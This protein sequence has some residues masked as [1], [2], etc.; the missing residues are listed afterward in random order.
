[1]F[2]HKLEN[3]RSTGLSVCL[4]AFRTFGIH[5]TEV[6]VWDW[7]RMAFFGSDHETQSYAPFLVL[8]RKSSLFFGIID[9]FQHEASVFL[10]VM[11]RRGGVGGWW[12]H[13]RQ[14]LPFPMDFSIFSVRNF[15]TKPLKIASDRIFTNIDSDNCNFAEPCQNSFWA[16][17]KIVLIESNH[18]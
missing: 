7:F 17:W 18:L 6:K 16:S 4:P 12:G 10:W 14:G 2:Q 13:A 9:M 15:P 1:M 3:A 11:T 8:N 5:F